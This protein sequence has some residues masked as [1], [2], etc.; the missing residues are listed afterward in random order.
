MKATTREHSFS[1]G[2]KAEPPKDPS[3]QRA[4]ADFSRLRLP[5]YWGNCL[6]PLVVPSGLCFLD[7][8]CGIRIG[9]WKARS[10]CN[11]A[12][13]WPLGGLPLGS[14]RQKGLDLGNDFVESSVP[15]VCGL[16]VLRCHD[17][18]ISVHSIHRHLWKGRNDRPTGTLLP[19]HQQL[20]K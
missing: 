4:Q 6:W 9:G 20:K 1:V 3:W 12:Y 13:I 15:G 19:C 17:I 8:L 7:M 2:E 14:V 18:C 16:S 11:Q 10:P 5:L